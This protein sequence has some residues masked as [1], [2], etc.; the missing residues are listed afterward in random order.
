MSELKRQ[1]SREELLT[2]NGQPTH[3][4]NNTMAGLPDTANAF[5][6]VEDELSQNMP[7]PRKADATHSFTQAAKRVTI[8]IHRNQYLQH[9]SRNQM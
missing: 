4:R 5:D 2:M 7:R 9:Q 3:F 8:D 1:K 6:V